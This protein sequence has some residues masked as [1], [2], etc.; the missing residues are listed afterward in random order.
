MTIRHF[1]MT[2]AALVALVLAYLFLRAPGGDEAIGVP[3]PLAEAGP[4]ATG[5]GEI[6]AADLR[7]LGAPSV[8][9]MP[10]TASA[11]AGLGLAE[12][13]P[14]LDQVEDL[15]QAAIDGDAV[16]AAALAEGWHRCRSWQPIPEQ[17]ISARVER[18][19]AANYEMAESFLAAVPDEDERAA[20][21]EE[22]AGYDPAQVALDLEQAVRQEARL[23]AG[24]DD[25]GDRMHRLRQARRWQQRAAELGEVDSRRSLVTSAFRD[26]AWREAD[27]AALEHV[28]M[29]PVV[30]GMLAQG[31][32]QGDPYMLGEMAVFTGEGYFAPPD[33]LQG[34]AYSRAYLSL[35]DAARAEHWH[36][37][38]HGLR[39][40]GQVVALDARLAEQLGAANRRRAEA[41][42]GQLA[43]CCRDWMGP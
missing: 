5:S 19:V 17:D 9:A 18:Q 27:I 24:T 28:R 39:G 38:V 33:P 43:D 14:L 22:L 2:A 34:Y 1:V 13:V 29:K 40:Y 25:T 37:A 42:A 6:I 26:H 7:R 8:E 31:L 15:E 41:M 12:E 10:G 4:T 30:L 23:C 3:A 16:A 35:V 32:A 36:G 21:V 11:G 20:G